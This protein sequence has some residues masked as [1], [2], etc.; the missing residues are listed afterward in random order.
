MR[1]HLIMK[2]LNTDSFEGM[3]TPENVPTTGVVQLYCLLL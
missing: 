1:S 2:S 3:S